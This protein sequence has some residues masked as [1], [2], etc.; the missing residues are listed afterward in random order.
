MPL[1]RTPRLRLAR[2]GLWS[3]RLL[4]L[5]VAAVVAVAVAAPL[6]ALS[7]STTS[8]DFALVAWLLLGVHQLG[9]RWWPRRNGR[10]AWTARVAG[11]DAVEPGLVGRRSLAGWT[12][13]LAD[14]SLVTWT[15]VVITSYFPADREWGRIVRTLLALGA[16]AAVG[17]TAYREARFTG[18]L[19]LTAGGVRYGSRSYDWSN[20]DRVSL[21]KRDG[22]L[23]GVRLRLVRRASLEPAPVV[24]GRDTAVPEQRLA[25]AIEEYRSRPYV[26]AGGP[27]TA[28]EPAAEPA[29]R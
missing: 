14:L 4:S 13:L 29:G 23:N 3:R 9:R 25:A 12:D 1:L 17:W 7:R 19:A 21:H 27:V 8:D 10:L 11:R 15:A 20:I 5:V 16:A 2:D 6:L 18:R 22:R 28:P 24:G 26:L